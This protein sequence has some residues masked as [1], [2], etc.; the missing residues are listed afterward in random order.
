MKVYKSE[1]V[2]C[3]GGGGAIVAASSKEE[4]L[5]LMYEKEYEEYR[6]WDDDEHW[7]KPYYNDVTEFEEIPDLVYHGATPTV[8]MCNIYKE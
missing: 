3:Y 8:L 5:Q 2:G 1:F 6:E 7:F 4:A